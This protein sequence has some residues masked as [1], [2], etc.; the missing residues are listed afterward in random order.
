MVDLIPSFLGNQIR[1][2]FSQENVQNRVENSLPYKLAQQ[3]RQVAQA[4]NQ[5]LARQGAKEG[6]IKDRSE[7]PNRNTDR[8]PYPGQQV[9]DPL[10]AA[11]AA[12]DYIYHAVE[13]P[14]NAGEFGLSWAANTG[15]S[16]GDYILSLFGAGEDKE[17][18]PKKT[19][20]ETYLAQGGPGGGAGMVAGGQ[21]GEG[22]PFPEINLGMRD[23]DTSKVKAPQYEGTP[24]NVWDVLAAGFANADFSGKLPD[25][26][27]A[28]NE[29]N[30]ITAEGNKSVTDAKN[31]TEEARASAERWQV[32]QEFAKEEM[33]QR[34]ALAQAN[35]A[36]AKWQAMQPRAI[37]GNK[38][39]WRDANGNIHWE[40]LDKQGE[41]R[42]L[43]QNAALSDLAQMSDK[44]LSR[45]TPKKIMQR[46]QQQS[47]LLQDKNSQIPFMQNYYIQGLQ[48]IQGE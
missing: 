41:A 23:I 14:Q 27:K 4:I 45:M 5:G 11:V 13:N 22:I 3:G 40:Q 17:S 6:L 30:R 24:Y 29:M 36:L 10:G 19:W 34:N 21:G 44:E 8:L 18:T 46:A 2:Y 31:A 7:L 26:S 37:G 12:G 15:E 33:R 35:M 32:A 20:L 47:L 38:T 43:G 39:Y 48:M 42:T 28:V 1:E 25:F 9:V 16:I